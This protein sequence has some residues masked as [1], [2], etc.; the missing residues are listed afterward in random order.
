MSD[1]YLSEATKLFGRFQK[2]EVDANTMSYTLRPVVHQIC[3]LVAS[4]YARRGIQGSA[5]NLT[6]DLTQD[7]MFHLLTDSKRLFSSE[8]PIEPF[9]QQIARRKV[10]N[11]YMDLNT[12][13]FDSNDTQIQDELDHDAYH[14]TDTEYHFDFEGEVDREHARE[15]IRQVMLESKKE[16]SE[17][18]TMTPDDVLHADGP[19]LKV[20]M[21]YKITDV[22]DVRPAAP[23]APVRRSRRSPATGEIIKPQY[24]LNAD[25]QRLTHIMAK[26]HFTQEQY[27]LRLGIAKP[28]LASYLYGRTDSVP[29]HV[30]ESAELLLSDTDRLEAIKSFEIR[31]MPEIMTEWLSALGRKDVI[32]SKDNLK[33][34]ADIL[35]LNV[36]SLER[37]STS[38]IRPKAVK[39][40][41]YDKIVRTRSK[42]IK[43]P[44]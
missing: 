3:R 16:H 29:E 1:F 5:D 42:R 24:K 23:K 38:G 7:V 31:S 9:I 14:D 35:S 26:L 6:D 17:Q 2:D 37:W 33:F 25:Q 30:M 12:V 8:R 32:L 15:R 18:H 41:E 27:A 39:F 11:E 43:K 36:I 20:D 34:L 44:S 28:T 40:L 10:Y 19:P 22:T 4:K 21:R 13:Y